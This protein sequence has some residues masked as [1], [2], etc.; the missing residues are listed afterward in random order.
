MEKL[1]E[2]IHALCAVCGTILLQLAV[3]LFVNTYVGNQTGH[4]FDPASSFG[5]VC[6]ILSLF[7]PFLYA[8]I[9]FTV[10]L[11]FGKSRLHIMF[12]CVVSILAVTNTIAPFFVQFIYAG[13]VN[14]AFT[15]FLATA[16]TLFSMPAH[17]M[18][19][20]FNEAVNFFLSDFSGG[21]VFVFIAT[22][23]SF[24]LPVIL[25]TGYLLGLFARKREQEKEYTQ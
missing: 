9:C 14:N 3:L 8:I 24:L 6:M 23:L 4:F 20:A 1:R 17:S 12:G 5:G 22:F 11:V 16:A 19:Y 15:E 13:G 7:L 18:A 2:V 10:G 25:T 21:R